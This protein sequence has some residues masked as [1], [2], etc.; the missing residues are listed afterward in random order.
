LPLA[1]LN[2]FVGGIS[3]GRCAFLLHLDG[4]GS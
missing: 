4:C 2:I 1:S 3:R